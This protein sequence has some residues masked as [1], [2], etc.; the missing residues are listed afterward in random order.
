ME[1]PQ[2]NVTRC[3]NIGNAAEI[4][5][6]RIR[7]NAQKALLGLHPEFKNAG[8]IPTNLIRGVKEPIGEN[9][10]NFNA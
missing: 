5:K 3:P 9:H 8:K 1:M 6:S 7:T 10:F 2:I 4:L